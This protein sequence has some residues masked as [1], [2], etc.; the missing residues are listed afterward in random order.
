VRA[1][2]SLFLNITTTDI[3]SPYEVQMMA[4]EP[5]HIPHNKNAHVCTIKNN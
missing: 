5:V 4:L 1:Y 3:P 2:F